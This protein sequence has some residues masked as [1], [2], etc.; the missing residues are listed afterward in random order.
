[1]PAYCPV[2]HLGRQRIGSNRPE[3]QQVPRDSHG[4]GQRTNNACDQ[5]VY[6]WVTGR[7]ACAPVCLGHNSTAT[8]GC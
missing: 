1:M 4:A 2:M 8:G 3:L 7:C 5:G 6:V